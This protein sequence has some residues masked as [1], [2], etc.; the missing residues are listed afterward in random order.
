[1]L[2]LLTQESRVPSW[3]LTKQVE[4]SMVI[5]AYFKKPVHSIDKCYKI[6]G[7]LADFKFT[8]PEKFQGP[9][10]VNNVLT[11]NEEGEQGTGILE[12]KLLTQKNVTHLL[13]LLQ[14]LQMG[15]QGASTSDGA[16]NANCAGIPKFFK[17]PAC[18]FSN[19]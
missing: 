14:Q 12:G 19:Q 9:I 11:S 4:R 1:M 13:Q 3:L 8:N 6:H 18:F 5:C 16:A 10:Q 7:F 17:S 15:Q 2:Y